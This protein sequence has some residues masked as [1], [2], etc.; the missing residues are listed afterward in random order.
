MT[1]AVS[2]RCLRG[3]GADSGRVVGRRVQCGDESTTSNESPSPPSPAC[4][5]HPRHEPAESPDG[6]AVGVP[7]PD[8][9]AVL[10]RRPS[11]LKSPAGGA[12]CR[13]TADP[14][15]QPSRLATR[16][17][18]SVIRGAC[19]GGWHRR[20]RCTGSG[21][22]GAVASRPRCPTLSPRQRT[23]VGSAVADQPEERQSARRAARV[24]ALR[25][26]GR[27]EL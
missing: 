7:A 25:L 18:L 9:C 27:R 14:W 20:S 11:S 19:F 1:P 23:A 22:N 3:R 15:C 2:D 21:F 4:E 24:R 17:S 10:D 13:G 16:I 12:R 6:N 5:Q 26:A 8:A